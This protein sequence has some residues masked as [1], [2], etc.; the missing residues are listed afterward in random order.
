MASV[1]ALDQGTTSSRAIL[2]DRDGTASRDR[3]A[4]VPPDLSA[5]RLGRARRQRDLGDAIGRDAR[6]ARQGARRAPATSP[7]SA[8][9]TSARPPSCGTARPGRPIANAIVWQDRR[10]APMCDELRAAGHAPTFAAQDRARARRVLLRHQARAGCSTTSRARARAR[11][12]ASSRSAPSTP[13]SSG[14]HRR[15]RARAPMRRNA[16][17]TLLFNIHTGDWDDELLRCSTCRA[18]CCPRCVASSGV[19]GTTRD[20]RLRL[21]IAGIAGDQQAALFGQACFIAR[22]GQEH[23]R[24]RLL[25]AAEHRHQAPSRRATTC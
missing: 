24:H 12:A 1:L 22:A 25:P 19:C 17:R 15:P 20:R 2:F 9:P 16:C 8:S 10:T 6:G 7:R 23:L 3:A 14:T 11:S 21:P 4:R 5:A 13:G 18:R